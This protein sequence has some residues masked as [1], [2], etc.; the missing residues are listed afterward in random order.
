MR[1]SAKNGR[2]RTF[3][4]HVY[5]NKLAAKAKE[6]KGDTYH[7]AWPLGINGTLHKLLQEPLK[8]IARKTKYGTTG[9]FANV[10]RKE[11]ELKALAG[12]VKDLAAQAGTCKI[13]DKVV[14]M[15]RFVYEVNHT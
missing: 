12:P 14:T 3:R 4:T 2:K 13:L 9:H 6:G 7:Q 15:A 10:A 11:A 1:T 5:L 8:S